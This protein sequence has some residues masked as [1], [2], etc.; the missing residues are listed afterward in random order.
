MLS[1]GSKENVCRCRHFEAGSG[2]DKIL[3]GWDS[4]GWM[5]PYIS[6]RSQPNKVELLMPLETLMDKRIPQELKKQLRHVLPLHPADIT[7]VL[8][9]LTRLGFLISEGHG[10]GTTY[11]LSSGTDAQTLKETLK[12][13]LQADNKTLHETLQA[14]NET[15]HGDK[16]AINPMPR[17]MLRKELTEKIVEFC[18]EWRTAEEIAD[19]VQRSKRYLSNEILPK[20]GNLLELQY[21]QVKR[22]PDQKYRRKGR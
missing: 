9:K 11:E 14:D 17:R 6:E 18:S 5:R 19:F 2:G 12:E 15:L 4:I 1:N 7:H 8:Q 13:T 10:R 21:P 3:K 22:H 16:D 20:M